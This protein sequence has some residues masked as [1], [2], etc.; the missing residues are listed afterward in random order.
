MGRAAA[1]EPDL[2]APDQEIELKLTCRDPLYLAGITATP[3]LAAARDKSIRRLDSLYYDTQDQRLR[4]AG[5]TLRVREVGDRFVM[6]VKQRQDGG[7]ARFEREEALPSATLDREAL[8][9]LL[10]P[11]VL[12]GLGDAPVLPLFSSRIEREMGTLDFAG[13]T[14]EVALDRGRIVA[15]ERSEA[16][17]EIELELKRGSPAALYQLALELAGHAP[18]VPSGR[19]K[20]DRGFALTSNS[21]DPEPPNKLRLSRRSTADEALGAILGVALAQAV[22]HLPR[23]AGRA[24]P[25]GVHQL[26]VALRRLRMGLWLVK[27]AGGG[28][29]VQILTEEVRWLAGEL[30]DAR[31]WD[32]LATEIVP[33]AAASGDGRNGFRK[34]GQNVDAQRRQAHQRAADAVSSGRAGRLL[35]SI[36]LLQSRH[37]WREVMPKG[38]RRLDKPVK[39]MAKD[40]LR[41]LHRRVLRRG[42]DFDSLD[43]EG[44]HRLRIALK[45]LRYA[46]DLFLP[47]LQR[48]KPARRQAAALKRLQDEFGRL[49]D[50]SRGSQLLTQL[51]GDVPAPEARGAIGRVLIAQQNIL[52]DGE[53]ALRRSWL[54]FIRKFE[55]RRGRK[56]RRH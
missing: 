39:G 47:L 28:A 29:L 7:L 14:I 32:V 36:G 33:A 23:V 27:R 30:G 38:G 20:S 1:P 50:A 26:R 49:N 40:A 3:I 21:A 55:P 43:A 19:T 22:H 2:V 56:R 17:A 51:A 37:G 31:D 24:D 15:G 10:P 42:R 6:T 52:A 5:F 8:G 46:A 53:P 16:V 12:D 18:L 41:A 54:D 45:S 44:R 13:S 48:R 34:L 4:R 9:R 11:E 35:L 25:E